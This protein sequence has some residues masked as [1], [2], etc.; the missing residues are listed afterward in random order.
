MTLVGAAGAGSKTACALRAGA[1]G[2]LE[3][4]ACDHYI[5]TTTTTIIISS[6][7]TT[8]IITIINITIIISNITVASCFP[9]ASKC[10]E[11]VAVPRPVGGP[12]L[13]LSAVPAVARS[14]CWR[15][16]RFSLQWWPR[17]LVH[18]TGRSSPGWKER[19]IIC[20]LGW[21]PLPPPQPGA[22]RMDRWNLVVT[23][24]FRRISPHLVT[25]IEKAASGTKW[26]VTRHVNDGSVVQPLAKAVPKSKAAPRDSTFGHIR[27]IAGCARF[28]AAR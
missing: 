4:P 15:A 7:T 24:A 19:S 9:Q 23:E 5:I 20:E 21:R 3:V 22:A 27:I 25:I 12:R 18:T 13:A 6:I 16:V 17:L 1:V 28:F 8:T 2:R 10:R 26:Q 11:G 14:S